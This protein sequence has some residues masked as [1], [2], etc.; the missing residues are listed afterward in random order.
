MFI[1]LFLNKLTTW[2]KAL[3]HLA[4][5]DWLVYDANH[6]S[7][8]VRLSSGFEWVLSGP[9]PSVVHIAWCFRHPRKCLELIHAT[10]GGF[11][12]HELLQIPD[13]RNTGGLVLIRWSVHHILNESHTSWPMYHR[14]EA[15][16][17]C[18]PVTRHPSHS[19]L[20]AFSEAASSSC[21]ASYKIN[22]SE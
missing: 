20:L 19:H 8:V 22:I 2:P 14:F 12:R 11:L 21:W 18:C 6:Q 5:R 4:P 16:T 9:Y 7:S 15:G 1:F 13:S 10:P 17:T 3:D